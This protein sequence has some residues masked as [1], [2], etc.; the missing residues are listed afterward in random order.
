METV[1]V[2]YNEAAQ[3]SGKV[4]NFRPFGSRVLLKFIE[5]DTHGVLLPESVDRQSLG[6]WARV[7][8]VGPG[9]L[10]PDGTY[11][12]VA[13]QVGARVLLPPHPVTGVT[14]DGET[15]IVC[16]EN[17]LMGELAEGGA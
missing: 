16:H 11:Q 8:A 3:G 12:P 4:P 15:W 17:E 14:I 6:N 5:P 7:V 1:V 10:R 13:M 2:N 9:V